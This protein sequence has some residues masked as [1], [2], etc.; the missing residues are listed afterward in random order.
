[1]LKLAQKRGMVAKADR[2]LEIENPTPPVRARIQKKRMK[3]QQEVERLE[4]EIRDKVGPDGKLPE[5]FS[6]G[7]GAFRDPVMEERGYEFDPERNQYFEEISVKEA[8][9]ENPELAKIFEGSDQLTIRS[10]FSPRDETPVPLLSEAREKSEAVKP[11]EDRNLGLVKIISDRTGRIRTIRD[12]D[13][14]PEGFRILTQE[15][16]DE[17]LASNEAK[18][19]ARDLASQSAYERM[20][21]QEQ[22]AMQR[23]AMDD[24][25]KRQATEDAMQALG[26]IGGFLRQGRERMFR[27][28]GSI[29]ALERAN[30]GMINQPVLSR[31]LSGL[32]RNYSTGPLARM[33]VP[34]GTPQGMFMGGAPGFRDFGPRGLDIEINPTTVAEA[35]AALEQQNAAQEQTADPAPVTRTAPTTVVDPFVAEPQTSDMGFD[36]AVQAYSAAP[37]LKVNPFFSAPGVSDYRTPEGAEELARTSPG[38]TPFEPGMLLYEG[39]DVLQSPT[40]PEAGAGTGAGTGD[41]TGTTTTTTEPVSDTSVTTTTQGNNPFTYVDP[42]ATQDTTTTA[43]TTTTDPAATTTQT[44]T[45]TFV[46]PISQAVNEA[47]TQAASQTTT[48]DP[49]TTGPTAAEV[50]AQEA[51]TATAAATQAQETRVENAADKMEDAANKQVIADTANAALAQATN[52]GADAATVETLTLDADIKQQDADAAALEAELAVA[53]DP[54]PIYQG[55]T[56]GELLQASEQAQAAAGD[57]FT[58]PTDTGQVIDRGSFGTVDTTNTQGGIMSFL[59]QPNFDVS[60]AI[61]EYTTGYPSSQD[62]QIR[63]TYYPF[64]QLTDEQKENAYVAEVFKPVP[65]GTVGT[66]T[67]RF[68]PVRGRS[69]TTTT[70][71]TTTGT[72]TDSGADVGMA[73]VGV[74]TI[75]PGNINVNTN[76]LLMSL[77]EGGN[78][79]TGAQ[80]SLPGAFGLESNQRYQCPRG[81]VLTFANG[82][83]MCQSTKTDGGPGG[84]QPVPP[85]IVPVG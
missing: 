83:P 76:A 60:S 24:A 66:G 21:M 71:G 43:A 51:A 67:L 6:Q 74:G 56:Q 57:L 22:G 32:I 65:R 81:Y 59:G 31:G 75:D 82:V 50:L 84:R 79:N 40:G 26:G 42:V 53:L 16:L 39:T 5:G 27:K 12:F 80:S 18:R 58:T 47:A 34:R 44:T 30:G 73:G 29:R 41:T 49:V 38:Q 23:L 7:G 55:P 13:P 61:S 25:T 3:D 64:Q 68:R 33:S 63:Q 72:T 20:E 78:L 37:E 48:T 85:Q 10:Y 70:T 77:P 19:R 14:V 8:I 15:R 62:M 36:S 46:D 52:Q 1:M 9:E 11:M 35:L 45:E 2:E 54:D 17:V 4:Q 28:D 69:G